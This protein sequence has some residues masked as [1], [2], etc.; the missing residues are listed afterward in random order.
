MVAINSLA[1]LAVL[2]MVENEL[3]ADPQEILAR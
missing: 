1:L 3:P 2:V